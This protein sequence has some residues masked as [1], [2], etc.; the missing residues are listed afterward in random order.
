[1]NLEDAKTL[2]ELW[3]EHHNL[4]GWSFE[5]DK[6]QQRFGCCNFNKKRITLSRTLTALNSEAEVEDTILHEIAHALVGPRNGHNEIWRAKAIEIGC[7]GKRC[8]D[9]EKVISPK[10]KYR[11]FCKKC[12]FIFESLRRLYNRACGKCCEKFNKGRYDSRFLLKVE[13]NA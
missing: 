10:P 2:A 6:A 9:S 11:L 3:I 12:G 5:F 1:M 8:W 7:N 13:L 4:V